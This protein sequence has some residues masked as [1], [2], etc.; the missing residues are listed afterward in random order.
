[1][2]NNK[3]GREKTDRHPKIFCLTKPSFLSQIMKDF[4]FL[5][6][7]IYYC[8]HRLGPLKE[9]KKSTSSL[10]CDLPISLLCCFSHKLLKISFKL[11][12]N[13]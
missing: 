5:F 11:P 8:G 12:Q 1:M 2:T 4:R 7:Y 9:G 6:I 10:A 3:K 13:S